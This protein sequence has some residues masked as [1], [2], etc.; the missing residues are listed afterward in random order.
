MKVLLWHS[1]NI[2]FRQEMGRTRDEEKA[3][4]AGQPAV[5]STCP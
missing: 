4:G 5:F 2:A 1:G 3:F